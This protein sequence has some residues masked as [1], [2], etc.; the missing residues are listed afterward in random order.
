MQKNRFTCTNV[1]VLSK[2][3]LFSFMSRLSDLI[4]KEIRGTVIAYPFAS[5]S[6]H[7]LQ[8]LQNVLGNITL[9]NSIL[10]SALKSE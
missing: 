2:L 8:L 6:T 10:E 1:S 5:I 7:V 3:V 9:V 4:Q